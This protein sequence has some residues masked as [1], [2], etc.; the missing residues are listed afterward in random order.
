MTKKNKKRKNNANNI[1]CCNII[2]SNLITLM[3]KK[4]ICGE[5][6][7][8]KK[9]VES[10]NHEMDSWWSVGKDGYINHFYSR[11]EFSVSISRI[12]LSILSIMREGELRLQF[13]FAAQ[14]SLTF[15]FTANLATPETVLNTHTFNK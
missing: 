7:V 8:K 12:S 14:I 9:K 6:S 3:Y 15:L 11:R 13:L 2:L 4:R 5:N 10:E 1:T